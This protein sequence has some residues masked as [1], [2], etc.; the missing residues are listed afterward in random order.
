[1]FV[2]PHANDF[3]TLTARSDDACSLVNVGSMNV[4]S[5]SSSERENLKI[6]FYLFLYLSREC[7]ALC[8]SSVL[9]VV[10]AFCLDLKYNICYFTLPPLLRV[11][12]MKVNQLNFYRTLTCEIVCCKKVS[13]KRCRSI[14]PPVL[15][16]RP[17][18]VTTDNEIKRTRL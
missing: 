8:V 6:D 7:E 12:W 10:W 14:K 15:T 13:Y 16:A 3:S 1:M 17:W 2:V 4:F 18:H 9:G 5:T 11:C